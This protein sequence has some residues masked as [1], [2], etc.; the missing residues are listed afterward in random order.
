MQTNQNP[1]QNPTYSVEI[2]QDSY[3]IF[4]AKDVPSMELAVKIAL[5]THEVM[6]TPHIIHVIHDD[7]IDCTFV[8][9]AST[10]V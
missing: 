1:T 9:Y 5:H 2:K 10:S 3:K 7:I 6:N 4:F 8:R